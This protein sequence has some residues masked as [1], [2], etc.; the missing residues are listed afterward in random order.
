LGSNAGKAGKRYSPCNAKNGSLRHGKGK[1]DYN[2]GDGY[3]E[4]SCRHR[5]DEEGY[6]AELYVVV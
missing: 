1:D 4:A 6:S 2:L 3:V 5:S